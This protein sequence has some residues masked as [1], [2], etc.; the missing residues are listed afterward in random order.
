MQNEEQ[1]AFKFEDDAL[2]ESMQRDDR[3]AL[4]RR[5]RRVYGPEEER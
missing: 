1:L 2:A 5:E 4:S 3:P